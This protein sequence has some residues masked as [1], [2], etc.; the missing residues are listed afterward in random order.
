M[1]A[2]R[3]NRYD[4]R[5][6]IESILQ[7]LMIAAYMAPVAGSVPES[8]ESVAERILKLIERVAGRALE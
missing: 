6:E 8:P 1:P 2:P 5:L 7:E 3:L 4:L